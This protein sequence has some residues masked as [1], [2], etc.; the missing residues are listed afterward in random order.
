MKV[1]IAAFA[2]KF[3][4]FLTLRVFPTTL[5]HAILGFSRFCG[6]FPPLSYMLILT[7]LDFA[8]NSHY[9]LTYNSQ[10]PEALQVFPVALCIQISTCLYFAGNIS[11]F[12]VEIL[13]LILLH[14]QHRHRIFRHGHKL[15]VQRDRRFTGHKRCLQHFTFQRC[16]VIQ[17]GCT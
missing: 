16:A 10:F 2:C 9:P 7:S 14:F 1:L 17:S 8:G 11:T 15:S 13:G 6:Y 12:N 5:L 3:Q 4:L